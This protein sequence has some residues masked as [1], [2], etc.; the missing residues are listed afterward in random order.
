M[1][2]RAPYTPLGSCRLGRRGPGAGETPGDSAPRRGDSCPPRVADG[3]HGERGCLAA[4]GMPGRVPRRGVAPAARPVARAGRAA[5]APRVRRAIA[6]RAG[7]RGMFG[8]PGSADRGGGAAARRSWSARDIGGSMASRIA[9]AGGALVAGERGETIDV[10]RG[11]AL[12]GVL[13]VNLYFIAGEVRP[14]TDV[15]RAAT[16][17]REFIFTAKSYSLLALLFG[18]GFAIQRERARAQGRDFAPTFARRAGV[19]C[20]RCPPR[21]LPVV[22]R[23]PGRLRPPR[24]FPAPRP[25]GQLAR[26]PGLGRRV[27]RTRGDHQPGRGRAHGAGPAGNRRAAGG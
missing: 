15:D 8:G 27:A 21:Y 20:A 11:L 17:L 5:D 18:L 14:A 4:L 16:W 9:R 25:S 22:G 2:R 12:F 19:A 26:A 13:A 3:P 6:R 10:L 24:S 1:G 23:H 7:G